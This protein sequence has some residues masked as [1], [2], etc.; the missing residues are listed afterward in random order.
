MK[1][2]ADGHL[3]AEIF[4]YMDDG[5][6]MGHNPRITWAGAW[7]YASGCSR[8]GIQEEEDF[9]NGDTVPLGRYIHSH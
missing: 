5:C 7:A 1:I 4:V 6:P 9:A 2:R 8:R 3:V